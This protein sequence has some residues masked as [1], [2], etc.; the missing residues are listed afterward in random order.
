[1]LNERNV[2]TCSYYTLGMQAP[3]DVFLR[4]T[5]TADDGECEPHPKTKKRRTTKRISYGCREVR[6][7]F[8]RR[9]KRGELLDEVRERVTVRTG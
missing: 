2:E 1:M 3:P 6:L 5:W 7:A 4:F 8:L 9:I